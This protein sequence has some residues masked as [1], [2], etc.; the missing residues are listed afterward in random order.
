MNALPAACD[1]TNAPPCIPSA[2]GSLAGIDGGVAAS[3]PT[4]G[5]PYYNAAA[6]PIQLSPYGTTW[7][8][9]GGWDDWGP[10]IGIAWRIDPKTTLRG[11]YGIVYDTT[12]GMEQDWK[13]NSGNW[14]GAGSVV[15]SIA[16]NQTGSPLA[17]VESTFGQVGTVLPAADPWSLGNWYMDPHIQDPRS[18]STT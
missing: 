7:G 4:T 14:P 18:S 1:V 9:N 16:M 17:T 5:T 15:S 10:R 11:G 13:G 2:D 12:M 3:D 6:P 8:A